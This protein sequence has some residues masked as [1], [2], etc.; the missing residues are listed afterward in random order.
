MIPSGASYVSRAVILAIASA[1]LSVWC[2]GFE[3]ARGAF[4]TGSL[5]D[6]EGQTIEVKG[7][8]LT[9]IRSAG[10]YTVEGNVRVT[11]SGWV[12]E[13]D[14]VF[15]DTEDADLSAEG[16]VSIRDEDGVITG[17]RLWVDYR[18]NTGLILKGRMVLGP[19]GGGT[20]QIDGREIWRDAPSRYRVKRGSFTTCDC[21]GEIP[22][23]WKFRYREASVTVGDYARFRGLSFHLF[24]LPVLYS[25]ALFYPVKTGRQ[26]G[27]LIP[28][29]SYSRH[30]GF[31]LED[32]YFL[33]LSPS[34]DATLGLKVFSER[35]L[36]VGGQYRYRLT[37]GFPGGYAGGELNVTYRSEIFV[38]EEERLNPWTV[39]YRHQH[40]LSRR[41]W[42]G[43]DVTLRGEFVEEYEE[44]LEDRSVEYLK[45]SGFWRNRGDRVLTIAEVDF[46]DR[47]RGAQEEAVHRMPRLSLD[48]V[49]QPVP[50]TP[51]RFRSPL[52]FVTFLRFGDPLEALPRL[53]LK[54]NLSVPLSLGRVAGAVGEIG[55]QE[56]AYWVNPGEF[57]T[58]SE[59]ETFRDRTLGYGAARLETGMAREFLRED[60]SGWRHQVGG[61]IGYSRQELIRKEEV[62]IIDELDEIGNRRFVPYRFFTEL[63]YRDRPGMTRGRLMLEARQ[64]YNLIGEDFSDVYGRIFLR[65]GDWV[66]EATG[67]YNPFGKGFE[68][69]GATAA[70]RFRPWVGLGLAYRK[71]DQFAGRGD[72]NRVWL[73]EYLNS[74][75]ERGLSHDVKANV[76]L[77]L[78]QHILL[79]GQVTYSVEMER[80]R[81]G[82][83]SIT[84][85]SF[86]DCFRITLS[87][88]DRLQDEYDSLTLYTTLVGAEGGW[89]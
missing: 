60:G 3:P 42:A 76:S 61:E 77:S 66:G 58:P 69:F 26:S 35:G 31:Q 7:E 34:Q 40:D 33:A 1:A 29:F 59:G 74:E 87:Y 84:Y 13:A 16:G 70:Y 48:L 32:S 62:P 54:P 56:I 53:S 2:F 8:T 86:C 80:Y 71:L 15:L 5:L 89:W 67:I 78:F 22:P 88:L 39:Q 73:T 79:S 36:G 82:L 75:Y 38:P 11:G 9:Y 52:N 41:D 45:S 50:R 43:L 17:E 63:W 64:F 20:V 10:I 18:E 55:V 4:L 21:P 30:D 85:L 49:D 51:F 25:P 65:W 19:E 83:Y 6:R 27:F 81:E 14:R 46:I 68:D 12:V 23:P 44:T 57:D 37:A 47:L 24:E 72:L 28:H